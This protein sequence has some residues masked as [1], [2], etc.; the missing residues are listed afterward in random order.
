MIE[1]PT[2]FAASNPSKQMRSQFWTIGIFSLTIFSTQNNNWHSPKKLIVCQCF[3]WIAYNLT[4]N[5]HYCQNTNG[6]SIATC[7][8]AIWLSI[9]TKL[10]VSLGKVQT[11]LLPLL[12]S[13]KAIHYPTNIMV[14]A[15]SWRFQWQNLQFWWRNVHFL[16]WQC[17]IWAM[18]TVFMVLRGFPLMCVCRCF[19]GWTR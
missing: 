2:L 5:I 8:T 15:S 16:T 13:N 6:A 14:H 7:N 9:T 17:L 4:N 19:F 10:F 1:I 18:L 3:T 12:N 11:I